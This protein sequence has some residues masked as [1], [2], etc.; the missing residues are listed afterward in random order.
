MQLAFIFC[1]ILLCFSS[2]CSVAFLCVGCWVPFDSPVEIMMFYAL[3]FVIVFHWTQLCRLRISLKLNLW[4]TCSFYNIKLMS[5]E[6]SFLCLN[7]KSRRL[8]W[9]WASLDYLGALLETGYGLFLWFTLLP[10]GGYLLFVYKM[11]LLFDW[12][13]LMSG[14]S[15]WCQ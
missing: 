3:Y 13:S 5:E 15:H 11:L 8:T 14:T 1:L 4:F 9:Y 12:S 10:F 6:S 7:A 2:T